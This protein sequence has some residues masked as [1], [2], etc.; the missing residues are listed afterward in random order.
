MRKRPLEC[1]RSLREETDDGTR[2]RLR[3]TFEYFCPSRIV[4]KD[5]PG[6]GDNFSG[7]Q[8]RFQST[9]GWCERV[10][11]VNELHSWRFYTHVDFID[12]TIVKDDHDGHTKELSKY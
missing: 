5:G 12:F 11:S 8:K 4:S 6:D 7:S 10:G 2:V 1:K 3:D 9:S